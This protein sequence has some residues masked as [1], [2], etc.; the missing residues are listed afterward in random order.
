MMG[1]LDE[2]KLAHQSL[3]EKTSSYFFWRYSLAYGFFRHNLPNACLDN[4]DK[5]LFFD[6]GNS[7]ALNL[8][9]KC[10]YLKNCDEFVEWTSTNKHKFGINTHLRS[11]IWDHNACISNYIPLE[12]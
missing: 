5:V 8:K 1:N 9:A 6:D 7:G 3:I 10:L 4:I 11:K 12:E 2:I